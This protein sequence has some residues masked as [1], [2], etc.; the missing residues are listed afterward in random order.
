MALSNVKKESIKFNKDVFGNIFANKRRLESRLLGI[1]RVLERVD[2]AYLTKLQ[3]ELSAK[4]EHTLFQEKALWF[5]KSREQWIRLGGRD[6][7]FFHTQTFAKR[8]RNKV[9]SLN[10]PFGIW[11]TDPD[12][13]QV[14]TVNYFKNLF[15]NTEN[16]RTNS[17]VSHITPCPRTGTVHWRSL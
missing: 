5:Q 4:Y 3:K 7:R 1:Q 2:S 6:T 10:L 16:V 13:L 12:I 9:H 14:E 11:C 8:K 15:C 17:E